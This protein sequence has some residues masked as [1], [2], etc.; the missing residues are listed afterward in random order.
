MMH[1]KLLRCIKNSEFDQEIP[2][3]QTAD[4]PMILY[5]YIRHINKNRVKIIFSNHIC[6]IFAYVIRRL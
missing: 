6:F 5:C 1:E 2:Q 3:S 4:N